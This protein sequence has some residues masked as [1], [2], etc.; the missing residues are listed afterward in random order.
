MYERAEHGLA[1][2]W[3]EVEDDYL[4]A[5]ER[6]DDLVVH[7]QTTHGDRNNGKGD[8]LNDL[9]AL[10][11]ENCSGIEYLYSRSGVPGL[12]I[13]NHMLDVT[14]PPEG[15]VELMLESKAMGTPKHP[16]SEQAA[17]FGRPASQDV[18]KRVKE[19]G[20]K[21]IDIKAQ[22]GHQ[23]AQQGELATVTGDLSAWLREMKPRS[24]LMISARVVDENDLR[25]MVAAAGVATLVSDGVG[26]FCYTPVSRGSWTR[27][28]AVNVPPNIAMGSVLYRVAQELM[29]IKD[30]T[31]EP[32][33]PSPI[34]QVKSI[35]LP[36]DAT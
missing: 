8:F 24:Y 1:K 17:E 13:P 14:Y 9:F 6:F 16:A 27:Y 5:M 21:A 33:A 22:Y 20:F 19:V 28:K 36:H 30:R 10:L 25:R 32:L 7:G 15:I 29:A 23:R 18:D 4:R 26:L 11:L 3:N 34:E 31:P 35:P 2:T 12:F